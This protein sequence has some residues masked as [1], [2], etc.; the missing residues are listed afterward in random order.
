M[1]NL[2]T[3]NKPMES[4]SSPQSIWT[5]ILS[6]VLT[7][8]IIGGGFY[9]WQKAQI[10]TLRQEI[11]DLKTQNEELSEETETLKDNASESTTEVK[12]NEAVTVKTEPTVDTSY[13]TSALCTDTPTGTD[14][15]RD[16]YPID[17]KYD[18]LGFL[19]QL[20]TAYNCG[21]ARVSKIF[22]VDGNNYTLGSAIWLKSNP[23]QSLISTFKSIGFKCGEDVSDVSC[24]KWEL[25]DS[26]KVDDLIKLEPYSENFEADDCRNC[27]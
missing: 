27:G 20:F 4:Q 23:S 9:F 6:V 26:V 10:D 15:G 16:V 19:G 1:E 21:Q 11:Q 18:G 25:W 17:P 2:S 8:V 13:S 14:I 3:N 24:K 12:T 22:G 7:A 5:I